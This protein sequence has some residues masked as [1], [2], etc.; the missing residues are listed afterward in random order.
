MSVKKYYAI[1]S[2]DS[3]LNNSFELNRPLLLLL[4]GKDRKKTE[5]IL[6]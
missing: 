3:N 4:W 6:R 5:S 1:V 2:Q